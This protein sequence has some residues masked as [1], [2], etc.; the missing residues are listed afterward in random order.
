MPWLISNSP[1]LSTLKS[2][3]VMQNYIIPFVIIGFL[4]F[5]LKSNL[6]SFFF[7]V[8]T[9]FLLIYLQASSNEAK[10]NPSG[11]PSKPNTK[12]SPKNTIPFPFP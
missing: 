9:S 4:P 8:L 12:F 11:F 3:P 10:S 5:S 1:N 6:T 7:Y 2:D